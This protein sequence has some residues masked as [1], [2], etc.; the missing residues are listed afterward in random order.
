MAILYATVV[1]TE[2]SVARGGTVR[3]K[4]QLGSGSLVCGSS[5]GF[6]KSKSAL[7]RL[8]KARLRRNPRPKEEI[9]FI[10]GDGDKIRRW[11]FMS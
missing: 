11:T 9:A 5:H 10:Q 1:T 4:A 7:E 3:F 6:A 8:E 2:G